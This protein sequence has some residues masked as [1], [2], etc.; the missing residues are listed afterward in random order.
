MDRRRLLTL[1]TA[2]IGVLAGCSTGTEG[3][4]TGTPR[5]TTTTATSTPS[6]ARATDTES[7]GPAF[8]HFVERT[9]RH[10]TIDGETFY[11]NGANNQYI[12][13]RRRNWMEELFADAESMG[14]TSMRIECA[15]GHEWVEPSLQTAPYEYSKAAF[16][17]LDLVID[18][19]GH[20]GIR[21]ILVLTDYWSPGGIQAYVDWSDTADERHEFYTDDQCQEMF[22]AFIEYL[23]ER[24]NTH[25]GVEYRNDP[26]IMMWELMNEPQLRSTADGDVHDDDLERRERQLQTWIEETSSFLKSRDGNH[27]VSTGIEGFYNEQKPWMGGQ[28]WYTKLAQDYIENHQPSTIDACSVHLYPD[29]FVHEDRCVPEENCVS[30]LEYHVEDGHEKLEK[31]V[32]LGEFGYPV[33]RLADDVDQQL[34]TRNELLA[35]WYDALEQFDADGA[36]VWTLYPHQMDIGDGGDGTYFLVFAEDEGTNRVISRFSERMNEKSGGQPG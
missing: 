25:T 7:R 3:S 32:Y 36:L 6:T 8:D 11:T 5:G 10:F 23:L 2:G 29:S 22:R 35:R 16:E 14:L 20:H 28:Q 12:Y 1:A 21:V 26:T 9:G 30:T 31:P 13:D 15:I 19:A 24:E 4:A 33:D 17:A 34:E 18:L 27:L